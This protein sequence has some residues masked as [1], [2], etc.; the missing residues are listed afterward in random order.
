VTDR[1]TASVVAL[2]FRLWLKEKH[3]N[4][5]ESQ[6]QPPYDFPQGE[7]SVLLKSWGNG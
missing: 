3:W 1:G 7:V 4:V 6:R 5:G 2:G